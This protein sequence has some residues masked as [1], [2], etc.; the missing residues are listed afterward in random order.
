[1]SVIAQEAHTVRC[2]TPALAG[3]RV[4]PTMTLVD[5]RVRAP[6][7]RQAISWRVVRARILEEGEGSK[8][9]MFLLTSAGLRVERRLLR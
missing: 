6:L 9:A 8:V 3:L 5:S 4:P 7:G 2:F 1:M